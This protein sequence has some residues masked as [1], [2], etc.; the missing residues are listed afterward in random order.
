MFELEE[1]DECDAPA[2]AGPIA[3]ADL[4]VEAIVD[5]GPDE[6]A[7][8]VEKK[9]EVTETTSVVTSTETLLDVVGGM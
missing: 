3:A 9:L 8:E 6:D 4:L 5:E 7:E 1:L 2:G